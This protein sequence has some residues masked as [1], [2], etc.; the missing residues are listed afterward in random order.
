MTESS[1]KERQKGAGT[2]GGNF[3]IMYSSRDSETKVVFRAVGI[4]RTSL[5]LSYKLAHELPSSE[6]A[7]PCADSP[8]ITK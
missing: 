6:G 8:G 5:V 7:Y 3:G 1:R 4:S 2:V